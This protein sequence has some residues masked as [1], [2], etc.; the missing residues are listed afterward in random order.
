MKLQTYVL[1]ERTW[2][3]LQINQHLNGFS[4]KEEFEEDFS[5]LG[6]V[7]TDGERSYIS[8]RDTDSP[9]EPYNLRLTNLES[10][11]DFEEITS[12]AI[13]GGV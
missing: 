11:Y 12:P 4:S 3:Y 8:R 5:R 10:V 13:R 9:F 6:E 1:Q 2:S 7:S